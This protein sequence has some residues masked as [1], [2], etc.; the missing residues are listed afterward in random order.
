MYPNDNSE[1]TTPPSEFDMMKKEETSDL[2]NATSY[3]NGVLA[4]VEAGHAS[5]AV[6]GDMEDG[7]TNYRDVRIPYY[8]W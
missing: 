6:F 7:D 5:D 8:L 3:G 4:N 1:T 2:T